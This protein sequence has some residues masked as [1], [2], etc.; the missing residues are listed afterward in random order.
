MKPVWEP[1]RRY[2]V[3]VDAHDGRPVSIEEIWEAVKDLHN[4]DRTVEGVW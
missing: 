3:G 1:I 2:E 4:M